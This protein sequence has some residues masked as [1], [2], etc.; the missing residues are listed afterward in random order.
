[1][2]AGTYVDSNSALHGF[3]YDS[4]VLT[5]TTTTLT[6]VP[7]PESL[8]L[9]R[10]R[11]FDCSRF[12]RQRHTCERRERTFMSGTT[13]VG[14]ALLTSGTASLTT[15][16]LPVGADSITAVYGGDSLLPG[17]LRRWS[18]R[19]STRPAPLRP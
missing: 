16:D 14:T 2:I 12:F 3:V 11:Y 8:G 18:A 10:T 13:S 17:A 6:P 9:S 5:A 7:T 1:M 15:T 4:S 19:R